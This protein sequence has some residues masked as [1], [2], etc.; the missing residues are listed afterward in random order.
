[1]RVRAGSVTVGARSIE[2]TNVLLAY[3]GSDAARRAVGAVVGLHRAGDTVTVVGVAE[4]VPLFGHAG[5]LRSPEQEQ[6]RARQLDE[7]MAT[8]A[9]HGI[10]ATTQAA[11]GDPATVILDEAARCG[12]D[13][14][15]VGT[16]GFGDAQRWLLGSV[17][18]KIVHHAH[19]NVLVVR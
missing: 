17:S 4:G 8:L 11:H 9:G 19:C 6:E 7:V 5:G 12:A 3:D 10:D 2:M 15:V 16:R 18:T 1:M 14:I 13:L